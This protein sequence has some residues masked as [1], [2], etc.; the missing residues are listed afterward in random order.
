M[1]RVRSID[2]VGKEDLWVGGLQGCLWFT[3]IG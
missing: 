2:R 1:G 3:G